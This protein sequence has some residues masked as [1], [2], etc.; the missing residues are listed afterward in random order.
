MA[1]KSFKAVVRAI[2]NSSSGITLPAWLLNQEN[3]KDGDVVSLTLT[4][5]HK[6]KLY[7]CSECGYEVSLTEDEEIYCPAC[8]SENLEEQDE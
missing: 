6:N 3:L 1:V 2:S 8:D 7:L 4:E 5:A